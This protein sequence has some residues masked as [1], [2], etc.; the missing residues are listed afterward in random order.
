MVRSACESKMS[1][2]TRKLPPDRRDLAY[3]RKIMWAEWGGSSGKVERRLCLHLKTWVFTW[4]YYFKVVWLWSGSSK[5]LGLSFVTCKTRILILLQ[6]LLGDWKRKKVIKGQ[7]K[8]FILIITLIDVITYESTSGILWPSI[9]KQSYWCDN[10]IIPTITCPCY[11]APTSGKQKGVP[12]TERTFL[13]P[14]T[15][16]FFIP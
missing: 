9:K 16:L 2:R 3:F 15:P 5:S 6:E 14:P 11:W 4:L 1:N 13:L 10:H 7:V 8:E 12:T